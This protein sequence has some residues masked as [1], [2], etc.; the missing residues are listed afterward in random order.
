V[1][2]AFDKASREERIIDIATRVSRPAPLAE[3]VV[4]GKIAA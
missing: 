4:N 1:M 2:E 3:S